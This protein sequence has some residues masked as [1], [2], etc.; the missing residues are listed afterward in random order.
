MPFDSP[1]LILSNVLKD[2]TVGKI[3][4]PDFQ[5]EWKWDDDRIRSLLASISRDHPIGVVMMLAVDDHLN[6][7]PTAIAG[8]PVED[9][10]VPEQ[11]LLDGQQRLTSLY[12][13]LMSA[14]PVDTEDA[15]GKKLNRWYYIDMREALNDDPDMDEAILSIPADRQ[16]RED[17]GRRLL[18]D[19]STVEA[20]CA[21]EVFPLH[22]VFDNSALTDWQMA[23]CTSQER[24]ARWKAFYEVVI[25]PFFQYTVPAIVLT[26]E[27]PKEAV[28]TVFEKVNTGGVPLN[29]FEL[30]TATFA[31]DGF[32]LKPD[33]DQRRA[34]LAERR[35][36]R[37]VENTDFLQAVTLLATLQRRM[38]FEK[39]PSSPEKAPGVGCKRKDILNLRLDEYQEW[40]DVVTDAYEW[41]AK[42]LA[43]EY[44]FR[45]QDVPYRTQLVPLVVLRVLLGK[46]VDEY[47]VNRRI[48]QWFWCGVL[49][50]LY[51][52]TTE[53][54]FARDTEQV[55]SW[56]S[57]GSS[58]PNSVI[59]AGF[60]EQRLRSLR[61]RNSAAYKGIYALLMKGGCEDWLYRQALHMGTFFEYQID[62][63]HI[64]PK[65]WSDR[66]G[67][68]KEL[69][70]SIV[71]KTALAR[72]TNIVIGGRAPSEYLMTLQNK[73]VPAEELDGHLSTHQIDPAVLRD[74]D[75][76][77]F[78]VDRSE[79]LLKLIADAMGKAPI[80]DL[81]EDETPDAYEAEAEPDEDRAE[82]AESELAGELDKPATAPDNG[83]PAIAEGVPADIV[84][85]I[86][87]RA[88]PVAAD[89]AIKFARAAL[90]RDGVNLRAQKSKNEPSYFQ[91]RSSRFPQ[92]VAYVNLALNDLKVDYRL[93]SNHENYGM[94]R[95]RE[96]FYGMS[97]IME[98]ESDLEIGIR[99][100]DDALARPE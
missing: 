48:R 18:A 59:D 56:A 27:T 70:E 69:R 44:I 87:R 10:T 53:T 55:P 26:K 93:P 78:F 60:R 16:I 34:R 57:G 83:Q 90:S 40:A 61:T 47:A 4:L 20:E 98:N 3:Q 33:W 38:E 13:A 9:G 52:G 7:A 49:G 64:F 100:L 86:H 19:Y 2:V 28:C 73:G 37:E 97:L 94:A 30:L 11:L 89:I 81:G 84:E 25:K 8:T 17:F 42:F 51:G 67:I 41:T 62:I 91:I 46:H 96:N 29:V 31:S 88:G 72:T 6:F 76:S 75:F 95:P 39:L 82:I 45:P 43:E 63:H 80:R 66:N 68:D 92:V 35:V 74:D 12:Q 22:I 24:I 54:R 15:R 85:L 65:S 71:N 23:Y 14:R 99:L 58:V 50:E 5:R 21:G 32:R 36:L 77:A 79:R 1:D